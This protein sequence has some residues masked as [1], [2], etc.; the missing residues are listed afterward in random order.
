MAMETR[1]EIIDTKTSDGPMAVVITEPSE[2]THPN[3]LLFMDGPGIRPDLLNFA[4]RLAG[5]GYRVVIPDLYHRQGRMLPGFTEEQLKTDP[6]I[7]KKIFALIL[8]M[9]D[10]D[11]QAD[12]RDALAAADVAHDEPCLTL[13]F[14]LGARAV[15]WA[16]FSRPEKFV[17]GAAWH[18]SF[19]VDDKDD[20]PHLLVGDLQA[21]FFIGVGLADTVQSVEMHQPFFDA[22]EAMPNVGV[23]FFS[24]AEHGFTWPGRPNYDEAA[25]A[26]SWEKTTALFA[27]APV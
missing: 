13:G 12:G 17:A 3:V 23:E 21:P 18:P 27:S 7:G 6:D 8:T 11:I 1:Q 19:L 10:A 14:C 9:S 2:G 4:N 25:A 5:E 15:F 24:D 26:G 22:V 16:L 20:S